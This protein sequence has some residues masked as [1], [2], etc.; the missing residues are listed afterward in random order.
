MRRS[1]TNFYTGLQ[2]GWAL[3]RPYFS[4]EERFFAIGMLT[5]IIALN[6]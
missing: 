5:V 2:E 4:S 3:A 6:F 1:M